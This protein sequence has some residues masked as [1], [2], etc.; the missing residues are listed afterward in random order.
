MNTPDYRFRFEIIDAETGET[1][2]ADYCS[3]TD[4]D[5][6]GGCE[7]VDMHVASA[8]RAFPARCA[9]RLRAVPLRRRR[10]VDQEPSDAGHATGRAHQEGGPMTARRNPWALS[11]A[12]ARAREDAILNDFLAAMVEADRRFV[13]PEQA[14]AW[15]SWQF[16]AV[17]AEIMASL[18]RRSAR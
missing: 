11:K 6:F 17:R 3:L 16:D 9:R 5:E 4:I 10:C 18:M 2:I 13:D 7:S 14:W 1:V 12:E 15:L 8:L